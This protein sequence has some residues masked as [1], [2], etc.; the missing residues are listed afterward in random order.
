MLDEPPQPLAGMRV[1][2][3][4]DNPVNRLIVGAM[5]T[6]L[7]AEVLEATDGRVAIERASSE[8]RSLHAVLMDLHMPEI[9]GLEAT[10]RLRAQ[11]STADLP[12]IALTAA[13][14]EAERSQAQAAGMNGFLPKPAAEGDL[15]RALWAYV[16][17]GPGS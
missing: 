16:P 6:R 8:S 14:L 5:L 15:L 10:R 17:A 11:P 1:L 9:D 13:V 4:E 3:A 7:G 2:L 12:I